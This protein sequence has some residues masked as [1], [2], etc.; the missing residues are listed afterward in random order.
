MVLGCKSTKG[1]LCQD[2]NMPRGELKFP[3]RSKEKSKEEDGFLRTKWTNSKDCVWNLRKEKVDTQIRYGVSSKEGSY[4][5]HDKNSFVTTG[6]FLTRVDNGVKLSDRQKQRTS[7]ARPDYSIA[8]IHLKVDS[9][10]DSYLL[11]NYGFA[12]EGKKQEL[13]GHSY[14]FLR[15]IQRFTKS[16]YLFKRKSSK[17]NR[18]PKMPPIGYQLEK[19][20]SH[21]ITTIESATT[22]N[23]TAGCLHQDTEHR[24]RGGW[25]HTNNKLIPEVVKYF[26]DCS[27]DGQSNGED[28]VDENEFI[29]IEEHCDKSDNQW[30]TSYSGH[31][32]TCSGAMTCSRVRDH[33]TRMNRYKR[34]GFVAIS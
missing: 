19:A 28:H 25:I 5:I 15:G 17:L 12:A 6:D 23:F 4:S 20:E 34:S 21:K 10:R 22:V 18:K 27:D 3:E 9:L 8:D 14:S 32:T 29:G 31:Q 26:E 16:F 13:F 11:N 1:S 2:E 7:P 24:A 33:R 30:S